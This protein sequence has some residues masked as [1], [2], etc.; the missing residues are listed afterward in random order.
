M[1]KWLKTNAENA[2]YCREGIKISHATR[3]IN[4]Y[5]SDQANYS[6]ARSIVFRDGKK[7]RTSRK[8]WTD[9]SRIANDF[10]NR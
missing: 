3:D 8:E 7:C 6:S 1:K 9:D 4:T 5:F 10:V 2:R